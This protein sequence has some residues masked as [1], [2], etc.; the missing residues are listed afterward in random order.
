MPATA[1]TVYVTELRPHTPLVW[2]LITEGVATTLR[3]MLKLRAALLPQPF[4]ARTLRFPLAVNPLPKLS[5]MLLVPVP[6]TIVLPA[7]TVH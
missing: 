4:T 1:V 5:E 2:P 7:G 6:E 3:V